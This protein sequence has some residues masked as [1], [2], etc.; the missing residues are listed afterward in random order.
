MKYHRDKNGKEIRYAR[1]VKHD[2]GM[3]LE[4]MGTGAI[5]PGESKDEVCCWRPDEWM[6]GPY[7]MPIVYVPT[8]EVS[9]DIPL[10][11]KPKWMT[12]DSWGHFWK[13]FFDWGK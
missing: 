7:F 6:K 10:I 3:I 2:S 9:I 4:V 1:Y 12:W 11:T 5:I 8:K 13:W